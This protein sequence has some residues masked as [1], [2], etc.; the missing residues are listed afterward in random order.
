V[1][2]FRGI[3][4][5]NFAKIFF[6]KRVFI[7]ILLVPFC[8][9][10]QKYHEVSV[11]LS[12]PEVKTLGALGIAAEE[13]IYS[14]GRWHGFI[15]DAELEAVKKVGLTA[16][17]I[18]QD[19]SDYV[20]E[21]NSRMMSR[22]EEINNMIR[23]GEIN[24]NSGTKTADYLNYP[25][26]VHFELG[27]MG[28][29]Y[30]PDQ[31]LNEM[32]SMRLYYPQLI[33]QKMQMGN[34]LT[35]G[36]RMQYYVRI[37]KT[38]D[39]VTSK[40]RIMYNAL[41]HAREPMGMQQLM[42]FMWYL[43]ENYNTDAGVKYLVDNLEL[44]FVP[45][46]NPDGYA[47][48]FQTNPGGG[49]MWRKNRHDN[50]GGAM[51]VDLNRNFGYMWGY[52]NYGSSPDPNDETYR[53]TYA[54]SEAETQNFQTFCSQMKFKSVFNYHTYANQ[55]II[56]F[57]YETMYTPDS[58][59]QLLFTDR[60]TV[61]NGYVTGTPGSILYNTN[62]DAMDWEYG[63][64]VSKPRIIPMTTET[65]NGNDGFWP[66]PDR[67]IPLCKENMY[68]NLEFAKLTLP[69]A[70]I[71]DLGPVIH[72]L[73]DSWMPFSFMRIGL[74]DSVDYT[75][76]LKP[77]DSLLFASVG[78]P[79]TIHWPELNTAISDSI[80]Y[81]LK[82]G[83]Q[84]GQKYR[85]I[86][87]ISN[88][89]TVFRDTVSKYYG[90]PK[91]LISDSCNTMDNWT[92]NRWGPSAKTWHSAS[93]SLADSPTGPYINNANYPLSLKNPLLPGNSPVVVMDYWLSCSIEK[94]MDYCQVSVS[95]DNG[96]SWEPQNTRYTNHG[97][98]AQ[99]WP[100]PV[101][102]GFRGWSADRIVVENASGQQVMVKF[103]QRS[104]GD[105][106]IMDGTYLD[107]FRATVVDMTYNGTDPAG[108]LHG[109]ISDP[110]PNPCSGSFS[111]SYML[112]NGSG[113][114]KNLSSVTG[115]AS[116]Q[117]TDLTGNILLREAVLSASGTLH[118]NV[119]HLSPGLYLCRISW[120][121]GSTVV[122]KLLVAR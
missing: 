71:T 38:P 76:T 18:R 44:Y 31:V 15:S 62:G 67:I 104:D 108:E 23:R 19:I 43:L 54:F 39:V 87:E 83:I 40:P 117:L 107:D 56:P 8:L 51:G 96:S 16:D 49:G 77:L 17:V 73:R 91:V 115:N 47:Y 28:G 63:D 113:D 27:A 70:E 35:I 26:P 66:V 120:S 1:I 122:K 11:T 84:I 61:E 30:T 25:V 58:V 55:T 100:N 94:S 36:G 82:Q 93:K 86:W 9:Y 41:T 98:I 37:S 29:Y 101:Y 65:G 64:Q 116:L 105:G 7:L 78:A 79:K 10:S 106:V 2:A 95:R 69:Y 99:N 72:P 34:N 118:V 60:V 111:I 13:G 85:Y 68:A 109:F 50:G 110:M 20:S 89:L 97:S 121:G 21:R 32:D 6:M 80:Q 102:D 22:I 14:E 48:N 46:V 59:T 119:S 24:R 45:V 75:V 90:W 5:Q 42:F 92:S 81:S 57:C 53:G 112:P 74:T 52:D 114:G 33:S 88:G 3:F 103:T 4:L 12:K